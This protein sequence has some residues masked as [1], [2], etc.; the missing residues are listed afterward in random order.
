MTTQEPAV[1][2]K[3]QEEDGYA[4]GGIYWPIMADY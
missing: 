1:G 3:Q 2:V 4:L